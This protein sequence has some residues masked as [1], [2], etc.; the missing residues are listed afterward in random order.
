MPN[1]NHHTAVSQESPSLSPAAGGIGTIIHGEF[2]A[3]NVHWGRL[4]D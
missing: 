3:W 1:S 2:R 4:M